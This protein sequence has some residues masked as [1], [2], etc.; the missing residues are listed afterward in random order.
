MGDDYDVHGGTLTGVV[1]LN[2]TGSATAEGTVHVARNT[3]GA[4]RL[5]V[6][7]AGQPLASAEAT[8]AP[9][10]HVQVRVQLDAGIEAAARTWRFEVV[11]T[12]E[13]VVATLVAGTSGDAPVAIVSS[14]ALPYGFYTVRQVLGSDTGVAC[15][16]RAFY[17]VVAPV[18]AAT[19]LELAA[20]SAL[21]QFEIRPC[22]AL[23]ADPQVNIPI[24]TLAPG[25]F[26]PG[27]IGDAGVLPGVTP[28]NDVRG[29]QQAGDAPLPPRTGN[30]A[31]GAPSGS[32]PQLAAALF[33]LL[34]LTSISALAWPVA[35]PIPRSKR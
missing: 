6:L 23:P 1:A 33:G 7:L 18:S 32:W 31:P 27:V 16:G 34:T 15:T 26:G 13:Q 17:E 10:G 2:S 35:A 22:A 9:M 4:A 8:F 11:N 28:I 24:D 29:A 19:T 3:A 20:A 12:S 5:R 14:A 21:A 30:S 25:G